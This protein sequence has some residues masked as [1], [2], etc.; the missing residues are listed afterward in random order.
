MNKYIGGSLTIEYSLKDKKQEQ[1][2]SLLRNEVWTEHLHDVALSPE[3]FK[4]LSS[5]EES[6]NVL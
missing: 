3:K 5:S 4:P 6:L 2:P 1:T